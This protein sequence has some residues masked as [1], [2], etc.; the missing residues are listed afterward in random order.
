MNNAVSRSF[1]S[2][3]FLAPFDR[4]KQEKVY[5]TSLRKYVE[6]LALEQNDISFANEERLIYPTI[7]DFKSL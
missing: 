3:I 7:I 4:S 5:A 6:F 1:I 2:A